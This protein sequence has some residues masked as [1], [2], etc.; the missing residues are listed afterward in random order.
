MAMENETL[1]RELVRPRSPLIDL[2]PAAA[3]GP[4]PAANG[5]PEATAGDDL[6]PL[7]QPGDPYK[8]YSRPDNKALLTLTFLLRDS[9]EESFAYSDLRR[10]RLLPGKP[11]G[12]PVLVLRFVEAEVTDV[13]LEGGHLDTMR[14][15]IRYHRISWVRE[16]PPGAMLV[17]KS[18]AVITGIIIT[19][20][21]G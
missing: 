6:A 12:G 4:D 1:L 3:R 11:G 5:P 2:K 8:A 19:T 17:D 13:R 15:H 21:D 9:A 18:A 20:P 10:I 14:N 7:P 16:L